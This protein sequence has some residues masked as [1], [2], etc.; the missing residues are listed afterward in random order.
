ME[1]SESG[2]LYENSM[3]LIYQRSYRSYIGIANPFQDGN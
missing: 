1:A 3:I 2:S